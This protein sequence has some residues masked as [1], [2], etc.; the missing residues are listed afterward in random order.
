M[1]FSIHHLSLKEVI[2]E[3][4][5]VAEEEGAADEAKAPALE[6]KHIHLSSEQ[7]ARAGEIIDS[8]MGQRKCFCERVTLR[9]DRETRVEEIE[10][11][12]RKAR[13]GISKDLQR[14]VMRQR[15]NDLQ[16]ICKMKYQFGMGN[17]VVWYED[18]VLTAEYFGETVDGGPHGTGYK[19]WAYGASYFGD[20]VRGE[21]H[22]TRPGVHGVFNF[23]D[24]RTYKGTFDRNRRMGRGLKTWPRGHPIG[25][26]G[27]YDG[28]FSNGAEHGMGKRTYENGAVYEG[29][30]RYGVRDGPGCL[31]SPD[32]K[33]K[34]KRIFKDPPTEETDFAG[35]D[36]PSAPPQDWPTGDLLSL[37]TARLATVV[38]EQPDLYPAS[39]LA[40]RLPT[41]RKPLVAQA[42]VEVLTKDALKKAGGGKPGSVMSPGFIQL[43]P[44]IAWSDLSTMDVGGVR[45][46]KRDLAMLVYFLESSTSIRELRM[47]SCGLDDSTVAT[48]A[49]ILLKSPVEVLDLSW[50]KV[51]KA[52]AHAL[53]HALTTGCRQLTSVNLSGAAL[54]SSGADFL[55][56][57]LERNTTVRQLLLPYNDLG[58]TGAEALGQSLPRNASLEE[59]DLRGNK[60]GPAGGLAI[61]RGLMRNPGSLRV[62]RVADNKLGESVTTQLAASLR[63]SPGSGLRSFG[64]SPRELTGPNCIS[65]TMYGRKMKRKE[66]SPPA[67]TALS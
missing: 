2:H 56:E 31:T 42:F 10:A 39:E 40:A 8:M 37:C 17:Y 32:G 51:G 55:A 46:N 53:S 16:S 66:E 33:K 7:W 3:R 36:E 5:K 26:G 43:V 27:E 23:P 15:Q 14:W 28:E 59:L 29:R 45:M 58:P 47:A 20:F 57:M 25:G 18:E 6:A 52:G 50:N 1:A 35:G 64:A 67:A 41:V 65:G 12:T 49:K 61:A 30:F 22:T 4:T 38:A 24:G 63:G 62:V 11:Q 60:L 13:A 21:M 44:K 34:E 9:H 54:G 48:L 19:F